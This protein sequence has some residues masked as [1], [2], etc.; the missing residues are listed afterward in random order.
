MSQP[1]G[2]EA[3]PRRKEGGRSPRAFELSGGALCLDFVNTV[4]KRPTPERQ[5]L[6]TAYAD[7]VAWALQAGA[8]TAR[9][10]SALGSEASRRP[11]EARAILDRARA[12]RETLFEI[13]S[14]AAAGR[15]LPERE[16]ER[17]NPAI[18]ASFE[19]LRLSSGP[20]P[21]GRWAWVED[22]AALD[23]MLWPVIRSATELLTSPG[24]SRVRKCASETCDWL[25]IDH[26]KNRS[27]RWCDMT[28]CGNRDKVRRHRERR[29]R[30]RR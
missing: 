10:A 23:R 20:G 1:T 2:V 15:R 6:L 25:F 12:V 22:P 11:D 19:R 8:L 5:E 14:A 17:L 29:R 28:V 4:D 27:R 9:Q 7:V 16:L 26:S 13:L 24:P 21:V 3:T 18:A 30:R